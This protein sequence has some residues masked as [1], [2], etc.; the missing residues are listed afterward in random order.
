MQKK[1][2]AALASWLK[3]KEKRVIGYCDRLCE[4]SPA[5]NTEEDVAEIVILEMGQ[6]YFAK[7]LGIT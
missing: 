2:L 3:Y 5:W 7:F 1:M 4:V 6:V